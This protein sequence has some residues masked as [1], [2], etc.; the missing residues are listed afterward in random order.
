MKSLRENVCGAAKAARQKPLY[1]VT[2]K[3]MIDILL[4][5]GNYANENNLVKSDSQ[6]SLIDE[7]S[8]IEAVKKVNVVVWESRLHVMQL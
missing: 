6:G 3:M 5:N 1:P 4:G 8:L 7:P 2:K